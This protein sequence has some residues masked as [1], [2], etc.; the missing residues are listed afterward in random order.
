MQGLT[1][2]QSLTTKPA[3]VCQIL[4]DVSS[5]AVIYGSA[6]FQSSG[7]GKY[8]LCEVANELVNI[9]IPKVT[10]R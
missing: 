10:Q 8:D 5:D 9:V 6:A 3:D 1:A 4:V 2:V 7:E